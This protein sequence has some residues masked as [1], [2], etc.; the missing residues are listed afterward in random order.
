MTTPAFISSLPRPASRGALSGFNDQLRSELCKLRSVRSALW[1]L[2]G[3]VTSNVAIGALVGVFLVSRLSV[4]QQQGADPVR[5]SLIGLHLSQIAL[6]ALGVLTI[7]SEYGTGLIR[8]TLAATP[9][10][11]TVLAAKAVVLAGVGLAVGV[12]SCVAA[13]LVFHAAL[14]ADTSSALS[15]SLTSPGVLRAAVGGGVY[16]TLLGLLGLGLGAA[17]RSSAVAIAT[18]LGLLFVPVILV[19]MLPDT[20]QTTLGPYLPMNAANALYL[21]HPE[22]HGLSAA[23][24][25]GVFSLYTVLALAAGFTVI[26]HRDS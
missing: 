13:Y 4:A 21:L 10:R 7:T 23:A 14:P 6:G 2:L 9:R 18:L 8:A 17:L 26:H 24:G 16:L 11:R 1:T 20:W 5:L 15:R 25:L 12:L 3:A 22:P 19:G